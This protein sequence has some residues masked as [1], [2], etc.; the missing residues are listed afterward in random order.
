MAI[1]YEKVNDTTIRVIKPVEIRSDEKIYNLDFLKN[2]E[3]AILKQK[4]D[5]VLARDLELAEVRELIAQCEKLGVQSISELN[6]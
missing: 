4:E 5:F 2:Q 1:T 3:K 6:N